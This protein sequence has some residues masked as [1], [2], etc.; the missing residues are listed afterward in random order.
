MAVDL[1]GETLT[2]R[3]IDYTIR[4]RISGGYMIT[5]ES[6]LTVESASGVIQLIPSLETADD[7]AAHI[8]PL[9][10]R[11]IRSSDTDTAGRLEILFDN[12]THIYVDP[13]EQYEAWTINGPGGRLVVSGPGGE[14]TEWSGDGTS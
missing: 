9:M 13:D 7:I 3:D 14:L 5:I 12:G 11:E 6:N 10:H 1:S 4:L 8:E 2:G